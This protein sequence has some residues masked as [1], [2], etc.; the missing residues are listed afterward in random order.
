MLTVS[1]PQ[2]MIPPTPVRDRLGADTVPKLEAPLVTD[3]GSEGT[4]EVRARTP[5][6][7]AEAA[8]VIPV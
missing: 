2:E 4:S 5:L 7:T 1:D 8:V 3:W 6:R